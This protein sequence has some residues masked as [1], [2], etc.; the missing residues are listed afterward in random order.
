MTINNFFK[1][2]KN[3]LKVVLLY[4]VFNW[5]VLALIFKNLRPSILKICGANIGNNVYVSRGCYF[6]NHLESL[7]I[8]NDVLISPNVTFIMHKRDLS[9]FKYGD[10]YNKCI[11]I[12]MPIKICNNCSIGTGSLIMPGVTIGEGSSVGAGS[13]VTKDVEPWTIVA[14]TPAKVIKRIQ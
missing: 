14:G 13:V 4:H 7:T 1:K 3:G 9:K 12:V 8:G 11:H 2:I 6:D 5:H 10:I